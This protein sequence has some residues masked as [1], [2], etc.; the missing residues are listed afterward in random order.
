MA[1]IEVGRC[2]LSG[3]RKAVLWQSGRSGEI[4]DIRHIVLDLRE[5]VVDL[6][7]LRRAA[8]SARAV[9][10]AGRRTR[11]C[12]GFVILTE[13]TFGR[14]R[15]PMI[16][17]PGGCACPVEAQYLRIRAACRI[18]IQRHEKRIRAEVGCRDTQQVRACVPT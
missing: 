17:P 18:E 1:R 6:E 16:R 3:K 9:A 8:C 4:E 2:A 10:V 7:L 5:G 12:R 11:G 13:P 14:G 15:P